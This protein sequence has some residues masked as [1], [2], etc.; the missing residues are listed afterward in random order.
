MIRLLRLWR[1]SAWDLR[2]LWFALRHP[3]R[4]VW[5]L[6]VVLVLGFYALEPLNFVMPVIG[7]VDDFIVLPLVL[8]LL[9]SFLPLDIRTGFGLKKISAR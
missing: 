2:L 7:V 6:P 3:H 5:L 9:V 1:L 8:H 4:P